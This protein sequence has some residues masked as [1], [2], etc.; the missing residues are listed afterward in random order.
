MRELMRIKYLVLF[1]GFLLLASF[2]S[3]KGKY[4]EIAKNLEIFTNLY[5]EVNTYYVDDLDPSD[6]MKK[7]V[8]AMLA[9]LDPYTNYISET[10][11]E[12]YRY[13]TEGKFHGIGADVKD[14]G[15]DLLIVSVTEN[16]PA[17]SAG[18]SP[19]DVILKVNGESA[20][21]RT[22]DD[23]LA[24]FKGTPGTS[25][26]LTVKKHKG[27]VKK[28]KLVRADVAIQNV[29]YSGMLDNNIGYI[30]L[31]VF[32]Q[33]AAGNIKK[34][35]LDLKSSHPEM[36]GLILDLRGNGG[37][38]L[39]EAVNIVNI[40]EPANQLVVNTKGKVIEWDRTYST[41]GEPTDLEIP[42]AIM[43]NKNSASASEIVSGCIQDL[44]RGV[45]IGQRTY[46]KGL[47][48]NTKDLGYNSKVKL[49]IA[50][51]YI[52][53]KRCIQ[54]VRYD[55]NGEPVHVADDERSIFY[56][57]NGRPVLDGGGIAPDIKLEEKGNTPLLKALK[58]QF[59][60]FNFVSDLVANGEKIDSIELYHFTKFDA[61]KQY[62][63]DHHFQYDTESDRLLKELKE[64][65]GE[66][67]LAASFDAKIENMLMTLENK[68]KQDL[69][70]SKGIIV[71]EIE[72]EL[73]SRLAHD[74]GRVR[75]SLRNDD[76][77]TVAIKVLKNKAQYEKILSG[78]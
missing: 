64:K 41:T 56:T 48:Q 42:L 35:F 78:K 14:Y 25:F 21:D 61:F 12:S 75:M 27:K 77:V 5:K 62:L 76:E 53:S 69:D 44:D 66:E 6:L 45:I 68:K 18:L 70:A 39:R 7:G 2:S 49:T 60:I 20:A 11:I 57:K 47:V 28:I 36:K 4:Y 10:D 59:M 72:K 33:N 29:P 16:S 24:V 3:D 8:D 63:A 32:S 71:N 46:G 31:T 13:Y 17:E 30:S 15:D 9:S 22:A 52:P 50:K 1:G 38:L 37:G 54:S 26:S 43:T 55:E 74:E 65:S 58:A 51:Y 40:F 23:L 19:G 67:G 34:A 73:A